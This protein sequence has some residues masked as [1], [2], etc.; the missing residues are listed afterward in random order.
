MNN[1]SVYPGDVKMKSAIT[2]KHKTKCQATNPEKIRSILG[3]HPGNHVM[4]EVAKNKFIDISM[5]VYHIL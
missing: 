3:F 5:R 4:L 2:T 1:D